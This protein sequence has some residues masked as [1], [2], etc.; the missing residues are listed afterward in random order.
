VGT[1]LVLLTGS[2]LAGCASPVGVDA[3]PHAADPLCAE[4]VLALPREL[5]G[6]PRLTTS[7]QATAAWGDRDAPVVLRCGVE[8]PPPSTDPCV[9]ADDGAVVVDW[10]AVEAEPGADGAA[11]WTFTTYGRDPAVEVLVPAEV[12]ASR[13]TSF[14]ID[15]GPAV[16]RVE[17]T[18][19]CL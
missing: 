11:D 5:A 10:L 6:M 18:R 4:V 14:L 7:S 12:T 1:V 15:L 16:A 19:S 13:S 8:P 3:A 17:Q 9:S 2:A